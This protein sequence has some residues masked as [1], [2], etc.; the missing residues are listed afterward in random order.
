[1][2]GPLADA[3]VVRNAMRKDSALGSA[4]P[5]YENIFRFVRADIEDTLVDK[6]QREVQRL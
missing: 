3:N 1:M 2:V 4:K 6:L 5:S